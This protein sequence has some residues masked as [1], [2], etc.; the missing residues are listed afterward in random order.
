MRTPSSKFLPPNFCPRTFSK[1]SAEP[2]SRK[3][4]SFPSLFLSTPNPLICEL[5]LPAKV[6]RSTTTMLPTLFSPK[7][8]LR[9]GLAS[10]LLAPQVYG[11]SWNE[12]YQK[13]D[14]KGRYTGDYGYPRGFKDRIEPGGQD[15]SYMLPPPPNSKLQQQDLLCSEASRSPKNYR[16][17]FPRL[18]VQ[19]GDFVAMRYTE[20]GHVSKLEPG[21]PDKGGT[22]MVFATKEPKDEEKILDVLAW[23][24]AG[25]GGDKRG[26]LL[27][28]QN[29][30]DGRCYE[31]NAG[32]IATERKARNPTEVGSL[33][34]ET[35]VKIPDDFQTGGSYAIYWVWDWSPTDV[36]KD[37]Y[38]T[39]CA[40]FDV[41]SSLEAL[42]ANARNGLAQQDQ[43]SVAVQDFASRPL[44]ASDVP[45]LGEGGPAPSPTDPG[46]SR[47]SV[48]SSSTASNTPPAASP[49]S[50][51][52]EPTPPPEA[53]ETAAPTLP[54]AGEDGFVTVIVTERLTVTAAP[55]T[56]TATVSPEET[57]FQNQGGKG[58]ARAKRHLRIHAGA[59]AKAHH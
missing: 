45:Q 44:V 22:V 14:S 28:A 5:I 19:P 41:V 33:W 3:A 15:Q 46:E 1:F 37:Q 7:Q 17:N 32:E 38:Y 39:S 56:V 4:L 29:Y 54:P 25:D 43:M 10:L 21:R 30:D 35:D 50:T 12:Q 48:I 58:Q 42:S 6:D 47:K 2:G 52:A 11:H 34:C 18:K 27:S 59:A 23:N 31:N 55:A 57:P 16:D 8:A 51:D 26:R 36:D 49:T 40:D 9:V 13:I 53:T 24:A 20:N